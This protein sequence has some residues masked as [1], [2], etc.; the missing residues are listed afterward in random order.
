MINKTAKIRLLLIEDNKILREGIISILKPHR[1]IKIISESGKCGNTILDIHKLRP[2]VILLDLGLRSRNSLGV[3]E[4]FRKEF[5]GSKVIVMDLVPVQA[6]VIQFVKAGASGFIL[7]DAS[8]DEF[9]TTI[10]AVAEGVKVLPPRLDDSLFTQIIEHAVKSG[11]TKLVN[12]I[13]LTKREKEI[14]GFISKGITNKLIAQKLHVSE[15][16]VKSHI[17]NILE[18]LALRTRIETSDFMP[19]MRTLKVISKNISII[20]K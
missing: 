9:L 12:A 7:K 14:L 3:V 17:H 20:N 2:N 13:K 16:S 18:K 6:D 5:P 15:Y 19:V 10:R 1:D 11:K 8:P 4:M